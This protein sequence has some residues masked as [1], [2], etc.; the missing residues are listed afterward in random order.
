MRNIAWCPSPRRTPSGRTPPLR[1]RRWPSRWLCCL[2]GLDLCQIQPGSHVAV[3]GGGMI[4]QIMLQLARLAG[5]P[6]RPCWSRWRKSGRG[7]A[8]GGGPR[9]RPAGRR[10][11]PV[12]DRAV[13]RLDRG[14][15][16]CGAA[17]HDGQAVEL[18]GEKVDS[19]AVRIDRAGGQGHPRPF[20]LFQKRAGAEGLLYQSPP[21]RGRAV[22]S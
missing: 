4:G 5:R 16:V 1:R 15:R 12:P 18:A 21:P 9:R 17:L 8:A 11:G 20:E 22:E 10:C 6:S 13:R 7:P 14:D 3:I 2:H 19:Y